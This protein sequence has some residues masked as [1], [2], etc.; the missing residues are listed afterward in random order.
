MNAG[1]KKLQGSGLHVRD[2]RLLCWESGAWLNEIIL[3]HSE[4][5]KALGF[6]A[7]DLRIRIEGL[8]LQGWGLNHKHPKNRV[9][10]ACNM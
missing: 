8:G 6:G 2:D 1:S 10:S 3:S 4:L 9:R 7:W 5:C